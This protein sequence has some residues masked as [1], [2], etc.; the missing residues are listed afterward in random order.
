MWYLDGKQMYERVKPN[1]S[2]LLDTE[3][4]WEM[5]VPKERLITSFVNTMIHLHVNTLGFL[6]LLEESRL[7]NTGM[8]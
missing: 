3:T 4:E 1:Y 6:K 2:T 7:D 8:N 5:V